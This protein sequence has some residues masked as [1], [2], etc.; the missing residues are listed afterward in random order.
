MG[1]SGKRK[2]KEKEGNTIGIRFNYKPARKKG[3]A[4]NF[5]RSIKLPS[6]VSGID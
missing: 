1:Q 2:S 4:G 6:P 5:R 3:S